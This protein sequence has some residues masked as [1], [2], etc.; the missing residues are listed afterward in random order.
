[1]E[2]NFILQTD[3]Y[4]VSHKDQYPKGTTDVYSYFESRGGMFEE[5]VFFGLQCLLRKH[6]VGIRVTMD[7]ILEAQ[8]ILNDH[9]SPGAMNVVGWNHVVNHH[10]GKLPLSIHAVPEGTRVPISTPMITVVNTC[11]QCYWLTNYVETIL[12]RVWY[13]TTVATLS[14]EIK[15]VILAYLVKTGDPNLIDYKLHDFGYR[16]TSSEESAGI[17]GMAHLVN[18]MGTD[19]IIA[20]RYA[21]EYYDLSEMPAFSIPAAEHSTITSW[22]RDGEIDAYRNMLNLYGGKAPLFAVV[23]DSWD[24]YAACER[25]WGGLLKDEVVALDGK[26]TLIIRPDSG[27]PP[28]VVTRVLDILGNRF[29][30]SVNTRGFKVLPSYIRIIQ[31]DGNNYDSIGKILNAMERARWSADNVAFGMGGGLL[32]Q[33]NRDTQEFAFKCSSVTVLGEERDVWKE[34]AT[35]SSKNSKRGRFDP[36][37][38]GMVEV[39]RDGEILRAWRFDEIRERANRTRVR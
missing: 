12:V 13:P 16:A 8:R 36:D 5:V 18:F 20:L 32:Q 31:G 29:G 24:I 22:G 35:M 21:M 27:D 28:R 6:L 4:K 30:H 34:P 37:E 26:S 17:G 23:S 10:G 7:T 25:L 38:Y 19:T 2:P 3:S 33:V 1:M 11:N 9:L 39:F 15:D 14:R